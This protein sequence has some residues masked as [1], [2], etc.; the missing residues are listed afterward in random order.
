VTPVEK[1]A[2]RVLARH[3][4]Q[5]PYDLDTLVK[6]YADIEEHYFPFDADG[7]TVGIGGVN[8]PQILINSSPPLT[9]KKF[10]LAHELGHIIIPWHTG[11][12]VSHINPEGVNFEYREMETEANQFAAEL[13][14]PKAWLLDL[15]QNFTSVGRF[16]NKIVQESAASRDAVFIKFFNTIEIPI[17]CAELDT[18]GGLLK[19]YST[20]NAPTGVNLSGKNLIND[21]M[22]TTA[23]SEEV[24]SVGDREYKAWVFNNDIISDTETDPRPWREVL[25]QILD[26][27]DSHKLLPRIN[28][29]L[30]SQYSSHK[31]KTESE[32]CA[33]IIRS[34]DVRGI[35][36]VVVAHPLFSQYVIKRIKELMA[37]NKN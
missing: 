6:N 27:T 33:L 25:K 9:R 7:V 14:I 29:I 26:E 23:S 18:S 37:K 19:L 30:P 34:Y 17:I 8:K 32:I 28:A 2:A 5:P 20:G 31:Q 24:F 1:M 16:L 10:T 11:T 13:L 36:D 4:L 12:I 3:K 15:Q 35:F 21:T 22:F